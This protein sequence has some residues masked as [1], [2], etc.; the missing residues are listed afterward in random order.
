MSQSRC[1][2]RLTQWD[3]KQPIGT[4]KRYALKTF[5]CRNI[6]LDA[7][8]LCIRCSTRSRDTKSESRLHGLLTEPIPDDSHIY[9]G[10]WYNKQVER[11]GEPS[12]E[13]VKSAK[14]AQKIAEEWVENAW[15]IDAVGAVAAVPGIEKNPVIQEM[16]AKN[17]VLP[18]E[19]FII[20][21][22]T[23][24]PVVHVE[25][26]RYTIRKGIFNTIPV[27]ILP[28]GKMFTIDKNGEPETL[29]DELYSSLNE[30]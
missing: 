5:I 20:Y 11:F 22:E 1:H 8:L 13:W 6:I 3:S 21:K 30:E 23:D 29:L 15:T 4:S 26:D 17:R 27:W 25:T 12:E 18:K 19:S 16:P 24:D 14:D 7:A 28:N 9:G 10:A 2:A